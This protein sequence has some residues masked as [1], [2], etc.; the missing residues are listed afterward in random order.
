MR[1]AEGLQ[2]A[3][4]LR[5]AV[6]LGVLQ[7]D[8][9]VTRRAH[10]VVEAQPHQRPQVAPACTYEASSFLI[11]VSASGSADSCCLW[12]LNSHH[13]KTRP[14]MGQEHFKNQQTTRSS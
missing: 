9:A 11:G 12:G 5:E 2:G 6:V 8:A 10:A 13:T 4:H 7:V 1:L 14:I 3:H